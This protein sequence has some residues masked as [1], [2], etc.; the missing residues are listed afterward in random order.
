[1]MLLLLLMMMMI[2][3]A[4]AEVFVRQQ[5]VRHACLLARSLVR[6]RSQYAGLLL[7]VC[8][9]AYCVCLVVYR[10]SSFLCWSR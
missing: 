3:V 6:Y 2:M 8:P 5:L 9:S 10:L 1:M 7:S 4:A